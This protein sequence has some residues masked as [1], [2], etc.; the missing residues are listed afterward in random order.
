LIKDPNDILDKSIDYFEHLLNCDDVI[1]S[2][3]LLIWDEI[4]FS[5][6]ARIKRVEF[7][8][9]LINLIQ[10]S[11]KNS[12]IKI[13]IANSTYKLFK[14]ATSLRDGDVISPI[15]FNF[16]LEKVVRDMNISKCPTL[17]QTKI[18]LIAYAKWYCHHRR[19]YG[20][21]EKTL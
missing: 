14:V 6:S 19:K 11:M 17:N 9:K 13:E 15:L 16:V 7:C 10:A 21:D 20:D 3:A 12:E 5:G 18:G 1:D 2:F 8:K 4:M